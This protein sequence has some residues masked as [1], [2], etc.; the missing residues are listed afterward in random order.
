MRYFIKLSYN[1]TQYAGWQRQPN[2]IAVQEILEKNLSL[3]LREKIQL[4]GCGRTDTG[5]HAKGYFAHFDSENLPGLP[6]IDRI[7]RMLPADISISNIYLVPNEA[8]ARFDAIQRRYRYK[9]SLKKNPFESEFSW[10]YPFSAPPDLTKLNEAA[11]VLLAYRDFGPFC[12]SN[13]DALTRTCDLRESFW[14]Y[15]AA[16]QMLTYQVTSDR[17]LRGM[18]RL[19]VGMCIR[20]SAGKTDL[21]EVRFALDHQ[22]ILHGSWLVPPQGLTL[23]DVRYPYPLN[24]LE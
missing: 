9:V 19:I 6:L 14:T 12:K 16:D 7:N 21:D 8:H 2:A 11:S 5:V 18:I 10:E 15:N 4:T 20:V 1:G 3:V 22:S 13:T 23:L 24:P 17:F